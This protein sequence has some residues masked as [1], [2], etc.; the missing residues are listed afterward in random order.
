MENKRYCI[1]DGYYFREFERFFDDTKNTDQYQDEVY[2]DIRTFLDS[3]NLKS[4]LDIGCGSGYKLIKYFSDVDTIGMEVENTFDFLVLKYPNKRWVKS[5]FCDS[6][7]KDFQEKVDVVIA[8]D[9]IEHLLD[10]DQLLTFMKSIDCKYIVLST[11]ERDR[12]QPPGSTI[13]PP[14]NRRHIREWNFAEFET[15]VAMFFNIIEH[16]VVAHHDQY[17]IGENRLH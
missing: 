9:V 7:E 17:V 3:H 11:P 12:L 5:D 2:R 8:V 15:Y 13:G 6:Q 4:L 14:T 10:P 16:K 1:K